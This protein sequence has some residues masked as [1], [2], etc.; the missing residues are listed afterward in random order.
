MAHGVAVIWRLAHLPA[1]ILHLFTFYTTTALAVRLVL[2]TVAYREN[3]ELMFFPLILEKKEGTFSYAHKN[4]SILRAENKSAFFVSED[5]ST[6]AAPATIYMPADVARLVT[7]HVGGLVM[8]SIVANGLLTPKVW[9]QRNGAE[10]PRQ[11]LSNIFLKVLN[12]SPGT[13]TI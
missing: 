1:I 6:P 5:P 3:S 7:Y 8:L 10:I 2:E 11:R 12:L 13:M 9:P 4:R